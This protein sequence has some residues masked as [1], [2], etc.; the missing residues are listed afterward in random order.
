MLC[1][2]LP[3]TTLPRNVACPSD[4]VPMV[5]CVAAAYAV[6]WTANDAPVTSVAIASKLAI[7]DNR[8][9]CKDI[10]ETFLLPVAFKCE[11]CATR[12]ALQ[13]GMRYKG[14]RLNLRCAVQSAREACLSVEETSISW[15]G[16]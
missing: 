5:A 14:V 1:A 16:A 13:K 9:L 11:S 8:R 4:D 6:V 15:A 7:A 3:G 10:S 2:R 12:G